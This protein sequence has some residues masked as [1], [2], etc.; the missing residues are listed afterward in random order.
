[1][2]QSP[3]LQPGRS[4]TQSLFEFAG[5]PKAVI[6]T[7]VAFIACTTIGAAI[8]LFS[9]ASSAPKAVLE[10]SAAPAAISAPA[11]VVPQPEAVVADRWYEDTTA[12]AGSAPP[13]VSA[14]PIRDAWYVDQ[15]AARTVPA[16]SRQVR[17]SWYLDSANDGH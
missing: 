10:T 15:S 17:D 16:L 5:R 4:A 1:M 8:L 14:P 9:S 3:V 11:I 7:G 12:R 2:T 13:V 6:V